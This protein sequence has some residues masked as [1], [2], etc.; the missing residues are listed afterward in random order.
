MH[1]FK[2]M[3]LNTWASMREN[4]SSVFAYNKGGDKPVHLRRLI[5]AFVIHL[6]KSI[7]SKIATSEFSIF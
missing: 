1:I 5:S 2:R 6:L 7:I 4:L 3:T